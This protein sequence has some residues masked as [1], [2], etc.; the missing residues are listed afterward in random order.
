MSRSVISL[1]LVSAL[2]LAGCASTGGS[3]SVASEQESFDPSEKDGVDYAYVER[4]NRI[5]ERRGFVIKWVHPPQYRRPK[6][7]E[8]EPNTQ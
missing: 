6:A 1:G 2:F 4:M 8:P 7:A 3:T 5:A